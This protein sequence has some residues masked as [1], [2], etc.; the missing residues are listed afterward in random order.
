MAIF[1]RALRWTEGRDEQKRRIIHAR[2]HAH[3]HN[4]IRRKVARKV[5]GR[6]RKGLP[7]FDLILIS[8]PAGQSWLPLRDHYLA[9]MHPPFN[10]VLWRNLRWLSAHARLFGPGADAPRRSACIPARIHRSSRDNTTPLTDVRS[11]R[12]VYVCMCV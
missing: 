3:G 10:P 1:L 6:E 9:D 5:D 2:M 12:A 11:F 8:R 7:S 4:R